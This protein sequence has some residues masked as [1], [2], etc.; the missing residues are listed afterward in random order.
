MHNKSATEARYRP[1]GPDVY[2]LSGAIITVDGADIEFLKM[3]ASESANGRARICVHQSNGDGVHQMIIALHHSTYVPPHRHPK[4]AESFHVIDGRVVIVF[5][6]DDGATRQVV[7][8][9]APGAERPFMHRVSEPL[10]HTVIP[11]SEIVVFQEITDGPFDPTQVEFAPWAPDASDQN[12]VAKFKSRLLTN[13]L[14]DAGGL[15]TT[16]DK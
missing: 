9:E 14:S 8:L 2:Q 15:Q 16:D 10:F 11:I 1:I 6:E 4:K 5:F 12:A 3:K 7:D 13:R